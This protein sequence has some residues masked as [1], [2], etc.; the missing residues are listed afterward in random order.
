MWSTTLVGPTRV[1]VHSPDA[2]SQILIVLSEEPDA[3]CKPSGEN[4]TE[5]YDPQVFPVMDSILRP[6]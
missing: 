6:P 3:S 5:C 4:T 2:T 1:F